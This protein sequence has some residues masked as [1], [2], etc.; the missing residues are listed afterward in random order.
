MSF[1]LP[2]LRDPHRTIGERVFDFSRQVAIMAIVN[3]TP[4]SFYDAGTNFALEDAVAAALRAVEHGADWV[5]IGGVPFAPGEPL[6][7]DEEAA[8]VVPVVQALRHKS[9][10][11]ISVDTF[12][13]EVARRS[14]DAGATVINDTTGLSDPELAAVVAESEASLVIVH[15]RAQPRT[16]FARPEYTDVASEVRDFLAAKVEIARA[17]GIPESRL[18]VDP[19][20]D[21]NKNTL[22]SLEL[23]RR[24][25][26]ITALGLPTLVALSNKDFIGEVLDRPKSARLEGS[27]A[28]AVAC[29]LSGARVVRVHEVTESVAAV[30]MAEAILGL[31]QP[32]VLK[33]NMSDANER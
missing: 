25:D 30:R 5:D 8:R 19:G 15:S 31:R 10:V 12:H 28:A 33:H 24:L 4:D 16:Q 17:A 6:S 1:A 32:A 3:R 14:I 11:V 26:V 29:V 18:F 20:H 23:T 13:A 22:H 21:L 7:V 2:P 9:D 27:I